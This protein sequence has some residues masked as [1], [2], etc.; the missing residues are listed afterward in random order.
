MDT[1]QAE[2][3]DQ[4]ETFFLSNV[5]TVITVVSVCSTHHFLLIPAAKSCKSSLSTEKIIICSKF[6]CF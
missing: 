1:D 4:A 5:T 3:K 6:V 2:H